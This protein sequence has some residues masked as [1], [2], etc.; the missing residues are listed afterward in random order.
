MAD[1]VVVVIAGGFLNYTDLTL[2]ELRR[3]A[4]D[5][6]AEFVLWDKPAEKCPEDTSEFSQWS[7]AKIDVIKHYASQDKNLALIDADVY[8]VPGAP[9]IFDWLPASLALDPGYATKLPE[10]SKEFHTR[11]LEGDY[12]QAGVMVLSPEAC[13]T[14]AE[15]FDKVPQFEHTF[16]Q[17]YINCVIKESG[18]EVKTLPD[19]MNSLVCDKDINAHVGYLVHVTG[20]GLRTDKRTVLSQ[21]IE[22]VPYELTNSMGTFWTWPGQEAEYLKKMSPDFFSISDIAKSDPNVRM[23]LDL[24][25][26][27]GIFA[28]ICLKLFPQS[29]VHSVEPYPGN[30]KLWRKNVGSVIPEGDGQE[31][32]VSRAFIFPA[33]PWITTGESTMQTWRSDVIRNSLETSTPPRG[34]E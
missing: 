30:V 20:I 8:P 31:G 32:N 28:A 18:L 27:T 17:T 2:P 19:D 11:E 16:E 6:G 7:W 12:Y 21:L 14:L 3:Y 22:Q 5:I 15:Y 29:I 9:N 26:Y 1:N 10:F 13:K 25:A 34:M 24:G 23:I 4:E 33:V